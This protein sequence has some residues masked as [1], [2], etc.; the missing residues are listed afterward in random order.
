MIKFSDYIIFKEVSD[1]SVPEDD[2]YKL[3]SDDDDIS[4]EDWM[5]RFFKERPNISAAQA[6]HSYRNFLRLSRNKNN[7][8]T[9]EAL[10]VAEQVKQRVK[11]ERET[12]LDRKRQERED[13]E[14]EI[15]QKQALPQGNKGEK[16][17]LADFRR[18]LK[19]RYSEFENIIL[20]PEITPEAAALNLKGEFPDIQ[21]PL[22]PERVDYIRKTNKTR[23][24]K[25]PAST[26]SNDLDAFNKVVKNFS[27]QNAANILDFDPTHYNKESQALYSAR[28][29][30]KLL[31]SLNDNAKL[32]VMNL[33][34]N[35]IQLSQELGISPLYILY[36]RKALEKEGVLEP[37]DKWIQ[38]DKE[39]WIS[40]KVKSNDTSVNRG[41]VKDQEGIQSAEQDKLKGW[42]GPSVD[43]VFNARVRQT[44]FDPSKSR[45]NI[46][47]PLNKSTAKKRPMFF[48][49]PGGEDNLNWDQASQRVNEMAQKLT[50]GGHPKGMISAVIA[51]E[52]GINIKWVEEMLGLIS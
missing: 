8:S 14:R 18:R 51:L 15:N 10:K 36:V 48:H 17:T 35:Y 20:D 1:G 52:L 23:K 42:G 38:K 27:L 28:G 5:E 13:K 43:P 25:R 34:V 30:K 29:S 9:E 33:L 3:A 26:N 7:Y 41:Y 24:V 31:S 16:R 6:A 39:E 12:G 22:S 45:S 50:Q 40:G 37:I 47:S 49:L 44:G 11:Q 46:E 2:T 4:L 32:K 19:D 21:P